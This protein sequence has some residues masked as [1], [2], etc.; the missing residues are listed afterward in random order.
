MH[1]H[2][3]SFHQEQPQILTKANIKTPKK[4]QLREKQN[5]KEPNKKAEL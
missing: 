1:I 2:N 4:S 3:P 5:T